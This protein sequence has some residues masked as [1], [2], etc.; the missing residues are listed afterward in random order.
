MIWVILDR[1]VHLVTLMLLILMVCI[2]FNNNKTTEQV[3][4]FTLK[5]DGLH[6]QTLKAI[7][8]NVE[9]FETKFNKLAEI[10]DSYQVS[11]DQRVYIL[12]NRL[13]ELQAD[14]KSN[15]KIIN[16]NNSNAVIYQK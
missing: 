13:K 9:Y 10:Q 8:S 1:I 15:Q 3:G 7:S 16:T 4:N 5:V 2:I 14:K 11:T 12:E 6:A